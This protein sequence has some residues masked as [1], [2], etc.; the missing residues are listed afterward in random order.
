L[1][2]GLRCLAREARSDDGLE[3]R[4]TWTSACSGRK[5]LKEFMNLVASVSQIGSS[6]V[7]TSPMPRTKDESW[8]PK[9]FHI[10]VINLWRFTF[11]Y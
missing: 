3:A 5:V 9:E 10:I 7:G 8:P 6:T 1:K 2:Q 4:I 11:L